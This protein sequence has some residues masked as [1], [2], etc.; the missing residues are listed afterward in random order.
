MNVDQSP[1]L[2]IDRG[3]CS[4]AKKVRNVEDAGAKVAL[5]VNRDDGSDIN[6][7]VMSDD[8]TGKDLTIPALLISHKDGQII[9]DFWT[10]N[11]D[12]VEKITLDI[13]FEI[14]RLN[15][16]IGTK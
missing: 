16:K 8:G 6:M 7:I 12:Q 1:I 15:D 4:F 10:N 13:N 9:K 5:I 11:T 14:V 2:M 3:N